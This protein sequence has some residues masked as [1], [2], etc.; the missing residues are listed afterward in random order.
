MTYKNLLQALI[1]AMSF[2]VLST[3]ALAT[4]LV[5][6]IYKPL[7][8]HGNVHVGLHTSQQS[9][10]LFD[11]I[12]SSDYQAVQ[13]KT[14]EATTN[15]ITITFK[16][17]DEGVYAVS[18][19]HDTNNDGILNRQIFPYSGMP[20]ESFGFSKNHFNSFSMPKF[21]DGSVEVYGTVTEININLQ[22]NHSVAAKQFQQQIM[23]GSL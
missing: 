19:F 8:H 12:N 6:H 20:L 9:S 23:L 2:L 17:V 21:S 13:T 1:I 3:H 7:S 14:V 22:H 10:E 15:K 4:D 16:N 5:V 18:A 11:D